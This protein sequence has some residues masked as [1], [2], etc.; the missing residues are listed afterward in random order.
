MCENAFPPWIDSLP[1]P[2]RY[3]PFR[4]DRDPRLMAFR[5][6]VREFTRGIEQKI[7]PA[8]NFE[9]GLR[10]QE[11]LDAVRASSKSGKT[12]KLR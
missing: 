5:L 11:V 8:P 10:C 3:T 1:R 2:A 7:S 6:L 12:V 9:D 4:D